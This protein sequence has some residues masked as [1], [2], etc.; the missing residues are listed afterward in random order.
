MFTIIAVVPASSV[1]SAMLRVTLY[2]A[3]QATPKIVMSSHSRPVGRTQWCPIRSSDSAAVPTISRASASEPPA[4]CGET[5]RMTMN[6]LDQ[7]RS[8]TMIAITT[9]ADRRSVVRL[10]GGVVTGSG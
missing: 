4:K 3:N 10:C 7:A 2:A 8:V 5:P 1:C 9:D 6:A